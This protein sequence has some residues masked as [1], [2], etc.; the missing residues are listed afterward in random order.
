MNASGESRY[1][2]CS[3]L[4]VSFGIARDEVGDSGG[5]C[6]LRPSGAGDASGLSE[7]P[8]AVGERGKTLVLM[9]VASEEKK[10][11]GKAE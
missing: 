6:A 10:V 9:S 3:G 8:G 7:Y 5:G 11:G 4:S 1:S 2:R